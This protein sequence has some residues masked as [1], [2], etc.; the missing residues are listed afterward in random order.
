MHYLKS[1]S[2]VWLIQVPNEMG[3]VDQKNVDVF[4]E[5]GE[6]PRYRVNWWFEIGHLYFCWTRK[7]T[8]SS[9][10]PESNFPIHSWSSNQP[11]YYE[12]AWNI[13]AYKDSE[14]N[15]LEIGFHFPVRMF[16]WQLQMG[17][18]NEHIR[19]WFPLSSSD[20]HLATPDALELRLSYGEKRKKTRKLKS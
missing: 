15:I 18:W 3:V 13:H 12:A 20:V 14:M 6:R 11:T 10:F 9:I 7:E 17:F 2:I 1:S 8:I 5:G 4:V 16:I 19:D